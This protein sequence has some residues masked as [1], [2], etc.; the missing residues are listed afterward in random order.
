M[1]EPPKMFE[2]PIGDKKETHERQSAKDGLQKNIEE[3]K[4]RDIKKNWLREKFDKWR[5]ND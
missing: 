3:I 5:E 2:E 4:K 1:E